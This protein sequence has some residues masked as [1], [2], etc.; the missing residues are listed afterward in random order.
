MGMGKHISKHK[1]SR[2]F[3]IV[4]LLI[5]IVV[6]GIL[7]AITIA[8]YNGVQQ[9][10]RNAQTVSAVASWAKAIRL[11]EADKGSLPINTS[12]LGDSYGYGLTGTDTSGFQC[13][14][15]TSTVGN[16]L[17][18][19]FFTEMTPYISSKPQPSTTTTYVVSSTNWFRGAYYYP[20]TP[21]RIDYI[22]D[23]VV[24]CP[25]IGGLIF[26]SR[27]ATSTATRCIM[28]FGDS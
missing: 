4:E 5:V 12:C 20:A 8:A 28:N 15:D 24:D 6:I 16:N 21:H 7:A 1:L 27:T 2:A 25:A 3:T 18:T 13:R 9:R 17:N 26:Q 14:Q 19:S 11:Y 10:S 22:L 23:G